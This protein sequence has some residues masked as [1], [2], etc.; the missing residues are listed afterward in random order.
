[1]PKDRDSFKYK[2]WRVVV[3]TPFEYFIMTLIVLN[4]LLLMMKVG[5][6]PILIDWISYFYNNSWTVQSFNERRADQHIGQWAS[7]IFRMKNRLSQINLHNLLPTK[8]IR[9]LKALISFEL[10]K[11]QKSRKR[12][13]ETSRFR[14]KEPCMP[15]L[16]LGRHYCSRSR[17]R[18]WD[19]IRFLWKRM[20]M[21]PEW[22][23]IH[24]Q[25]GSF[26]HVTRI[27]FDICAR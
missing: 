20:C 26:G 27:H 8:V 9:G 12:K 22:Y 16:A 10:K 13:K 2:I 18:A 7:N 15:Y 4:T 23:L 17:I 14:P 24:H 6:R 25:N 1:M 19:S 3:S 11:K 5:Y 21:I